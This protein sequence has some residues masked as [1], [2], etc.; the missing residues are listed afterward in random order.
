MATQIGKN[1]NNIIFHC[2]PLARGKA[3]RNNTT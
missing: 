3:K 1:V 2:A